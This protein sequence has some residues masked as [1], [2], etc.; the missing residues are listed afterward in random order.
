MLPAQ[1]PALTSF[2]NPTGK[3]A[4]R[5]P[6]PIVPL[7]AL[8]L[9]SRSPTALPKGPSGSHLGAFVSG[10]GAGP[11]G[12]GPEGVSSGLWAG[13]RS[14][15]SS[16]SMGSRGG[17]SLSTASDVGELKAAGSGAIVGVCGGG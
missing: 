11:T 14:S 9:Y 7:P 3:T 17:T 6:S 4:K 15:T 5:S 13:A 10:A 16:A 2:A 1:L 12:A 8:I